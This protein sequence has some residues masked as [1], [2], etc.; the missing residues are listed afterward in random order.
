MCSRIPYVLTT[1]ILALLVSSP[2][3]AQTGGG[4]SSSGGGSASSGTTGPSRGGNSPSATSPSRADPTVNNRAVAPNAVPSPGNSTQP[5]QSSGT[6]PGATPG[7][8]RSDQ[9][10][11]GLQGTNGQDA[12]TVE[13]NFRGGSAPAT[14]QDGKPNADQP[15]TGG[16]QGMG[17]RSSTTDT[18]AYGRTLD[19]CVSAFDAANHMTKKEWRETCQR[20]TTR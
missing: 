14:A 13:P 19:E 2:I 1:S 4:A 15:G 11:T 16:I 20:T 9:G 12:P 17:E 6:A 3:V 18:G 8:P 10:A 7:I 5:S